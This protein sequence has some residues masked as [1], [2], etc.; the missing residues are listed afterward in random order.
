MEK[1]T[2]WTA[3]WRQ[4][5][6][7]S[8]WKHRN[9][10][11]DSGKYDPWKKRAREFDD[12]VRKKWAEDDP[13][14]NLVLS[15]IE[16]NMTVLD[17][18]AGT[19]RWAILLAQHLRQVTALDPSPTMLA[20]LRENLA[21][22]RIANVKVIDAAWPDADVPPHDVSICSH[23]MYGTEDLPHFVQRM[24]EVTRR[25]CYMI[26][27]VPTNDGVMREAA[28]HLWGQPHDS[29]NFIVGYNVLLQM[30]IYPN[31]LIDDRL[32]P[33]TSPDLDKALADIKNRFGLND[34]TEHDEYLRGL[35]RER[36]VP[37][38]GQY[39][40]PDGMRSALVYW[41]VG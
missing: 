33:W 1:V 34:C 21:N 12:N 10:N 5:T 16:P 23:A 15:R 13:I 30:G 35:L 8:S 20:V 32:H 17:I 22:E 36:L 26:F 31:V 2:D 6:Q 18:G 40:W 9:G 28:L 41:N 3:L 24:V 14:R 19:G 39:V 37:R 38:D 7:A 27:R 4:L 29:V 11:D 25:T